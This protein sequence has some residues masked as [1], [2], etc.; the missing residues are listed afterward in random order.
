MSR[1]DIAII[2]MGC[3]FP[4]ARSPEEFWKN[5]LGTESFFEPMPD[6]LWHMENFMCR[7]E[8][9]PG[10]S[11]TRVGAFIDPIDDFPFLEFKLPPASMKGNDRA[12]FAILS[13]ARQA[14]ADAG[15]APRSA[16][17]SEAVTVIG[18]SGVDQ[19]VHSTL[20]L[21]RHRYLRALRPH[22]QAAG[23]QP[24]L[25][26]TIAAELEEAL[27]RRGHVWHPSL[28]AV[29]SITA[30]LSNRVA[31]VLGVRGFNMTVDG[32]CASSLVALDV[33]CQAL[34]A[35]D[36][37][38]AI[39]GGAD[40]GVNPCVY[41][42]FAAVDG[43]SRRGVSNPFDRSAD[44]LIIGEGAGAV[45][46]K[47]L[48][49]ALADGD[50]IRAVIRGVGSSSDGAG[51]AIYAPSVEGRA[52]AMR[53]ALAVAE[54]TPEEVQ[55][56]ETHA[57]S[58]VVGDANEYD[59]IAAVY[60]ERR[61]AAPLVLGSAKW[62]IG[63]LKAASG[64]AGLIKV[65]LSM[66]RGVF[67]H[68]P[69]FE[70]LT[71]HAARPTDALSLPRDIRPWERSGGGARIG[72][73]TASGFGGVNYHA[74]VERREEYAPPRARNVPSR[75]VA[76]VGISCRVAGADAPDVFWR[77]LKTSADLFSAADPS[78]LGWEEHID[79]GPA[80]E[81]I[82]T[83][84]VA[85]IDAFDFDL[86][87]HKIFPTAVSQIAPTQLLAVD[88]ADSLLASAGSGLKE[89]KNIGASVGA[90]HDDHFA[91]IFMPL[92]T[93][94]YADCVRECPSAA[95]IDSA[96]LDECCAGAA[97]EIRMA[98]PPPTE[99]TLPGWM[100]NVIAGRVA[101]RLN[102]TG[103]NFAVDTACSSGVASL[104]P[105][106]YALM[107][108]R[109]DAMIAGGLNRQFS[110]VYAAAVGAI[111][112][113][114][115][116]VAR[117]FDADGGGFLIG[118]G[119]VLFLLKRRADAERDGD[120]IQAVIRAVSGSS[121]AD[122]RSMI[123]PTEEAMRRAIRRTL[124]R[125]G[126]APEEIALSDTHGS[127]NRLSD[128]VEARALAAELRPKAGAS[129]LW[130]TAT[131]SHIGHLWGGSGASS[132][133]ATALALRHGEAPAIR[134]L[135]T[136]RSEIGALASAVRPVRENEALPEGAAFGGVSSIGL[137]GA[138]YFV[139]L[140]APGRTTVKRFVPRARR[141]GES[142]RSQRR[143]GLGAYLLTAEN[144]AFVKRVAW[145][146]GRRHILEIS[147][148]YF[149]GRPEEVATIAANLA[150]VGLPCEG[151]ALDAVLDGLAAHYYEKLFSLV[152][153]YEAYWIARNRVDAGDALA[154]LSEARSSGRGVFLAQSHFGATYL[155]SSVLMSNGVE[156]GMVGLFPNPVGG[157]LQANIREFAARYGTARAHL[158]NLSDPEVDAP[159]EMLVRLRRGEVVAN[160]FDENNALSRPVRLLGHELY[161][162][163]G[164]DALLGRFT[165]NEIV[166]VTSFLV[167]ISDET[168]RLEIDRHRLD[169]G[170]IVQ[171]FYESL[172]RRVRRHPE[173]WHF[174]HELHESFVDKRARR[175]RG[176][177]PARELAHVHG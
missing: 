16:R 145:G 59:A 163:S 144:L 47:R 27:A 116:E 135:R 4:R 146:P 153:R 82:E 90:M 85:R 109:V 68:M 38:I 115:K 139:I 159:A 161:G 53:N 102:L 44:G 2:G 9:Q 62:Q 6:R 70:N 134:N 112:A 54:T 127:A 20:A 51:Q 177:V 88:L 132:V 75:E 106:V 126:V 63:H 100:T 165:D 140:G 170:D 107:F 94:E 95:A 21:R 172:E 130:I 168:F 111:G 22:L 167:R 174:A 32:A 18:A 13:A 162:G 26:D 142:P 77:N 99:H 101:N 93:E 3:V 31:Q 45:I 86:L 24:P 125:A 157:Q 40:L 33:A 60:G 164:M 154:V 29:G 152:K 73:V 89:R 176:A 103:P 143:S 34:M 175:C 56:L 49:D 84:S 117:P 23:C 173:Q 149:E 72:A 113:I 150:R 158:I 119:G 74:I 110:D 124:E 78:S 19:F 50:N 133:L 118:E 97:R 14:L 41:I 76:I 65:V 5:L 81:R 128:I 1:Y 58:T 136:V 108:G 169:A 48:E 120:E 39:A 160:V 42:G 57:T 10:K 123:A 148:E 156:A 114:G 98:G 171:S 52:L 121:E 12:Q 141:A 151:A 61:A 46:L 11:Y 30:S 83:R 28:V 37:R 166:V 155:M 15:M 55:F 17:L 36:A 71:P 96:I 147:R 87:R 35:G 104:L 131:K 80:G 91:E 66:E 25:Y 122:S 79:A 67:P 105:A 69:L 64:M 7:K 129:P 138:N 92:A 43:L 8:R 137:G